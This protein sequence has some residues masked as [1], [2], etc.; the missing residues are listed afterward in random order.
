MFLHKK[1]ITGQ[2]FYT[3]LSCDLQLAKMT[4]GHIITHHQFI[5]NL[6]FVWSKHFQCVSIRKKWIR[7]IEQTD[8]QGYINLSPALPR[9]KLNCLWGYNKTMIHPKYFNVTEKI[10]AY[11]NKNTCIDYQKRI[12]IYEFFIYTSTDEASQRHAFNS[13][14]QNVY[15]SFSG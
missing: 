9:K 8:G 4:L 7:Q 10:F 2:L 14:E 11:D 6:C 15:E 3:F 1:G 13:R 12:S 5:S